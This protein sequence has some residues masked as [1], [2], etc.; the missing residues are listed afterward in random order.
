VESAS[1]LDSSVKSLIHNPG[2]EQVVCLDVIDSGSGF[3]EKDLPYV[4]DRFY[5]A[6]P[7]RARKPFNPSLYST[8]SSGV[9]AQLVHSSK[10]NFSDSFQGGSGLGLAIVRQIVEAH[11]GTV[12]AS[13]HPETGGAWLQVRLPLQS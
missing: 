1:P 12:Q 7:S 5:R 10:E 9:A 4:F 6:D 11:Q 3:A 13:N 8:S 2:A